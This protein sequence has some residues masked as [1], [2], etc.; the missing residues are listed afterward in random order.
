M[1]APAASGKTHR[2]L[3]INR[4]QIVR[5][6]SV[7]AFISSLGGSCCLLAMTSKPY[8]WSVLGKVQ[9]QLQCRMV[10]TRLA[11]V[12]CGKRDDIL[13]VQLKDRGEVVEHIY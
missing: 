12:V 9:S 3:L 10:N 7:Q 5:R 6:S 11:A 8:A 1:A 4:P 13:G 2:N